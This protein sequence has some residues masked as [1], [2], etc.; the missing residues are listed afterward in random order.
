M[1]TI[2]AATS[3]AHSPFVVVGAALA[4]LGLVATTMAS[5]KRYVEAKLEKRM[6]EGGFVLALFG[7]IALVVGAAVELGNGHSVLGAITLFA[8]VIGIVV[9]LLLPNL[10]GCRARRKRNGVR[11]GPNG[12]PPGKPPAPRRDNDAD[13][14][15][16]E[17]QRSAVQGEVP[18]AEPE[19]REPGRR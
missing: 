16:G 2:L 10:V 13:N 17:H 6:V 7:G 18:E 19:T 9:I 4:V 5:R 3:D 15:V 14:E 11:N 1:H 8:V 12:V